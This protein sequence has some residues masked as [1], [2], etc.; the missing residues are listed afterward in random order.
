MGIYI[1]SL[2]FSPC[3]SHQ[4]S[5]HGT[6]TVGGFAC[7]S[8]RVWQTWRAS[9]SRGSSPQLHALPCRLSA[10]CRHRHACHPHGWTPNWA[11]PIRCIHQWECSRLG[12]FPDSARW[13]ILRARPLAWLVLLRAT[14]FQD[15]CPAYI[16]LYRMLVPTQTALARSLPLCVSWR[17]RLGRHLDVEPSHNIPFLSR[18]CAMPTSNRL[19]RCLHDSQKDGTVCPARLG[20]CRWCRLRDLCRHGQWWRRSQSSYSAFL[21]SA[22][23]TT[24]VPCHATLLFSM[25]YCVR[26]VLQQKGSS[27]HSVPRGMYH[28]RTDDSQ[29]VGWDSIVADVVPRACFHQW[30]EYHRF[31]PAS[32]G[33]LI[34]RSW[35]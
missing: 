21:V 9:R 33:W 28:G 8:R 22:F 25:H 26:R 17:L 35:G 12:T 24:A 30:V 13:G 10:R 6:C 2:S 11:V 23:W 7:W 31:A 15:S 29:T 1:R 32:F 3:S 20:S 16:L 14:Y 18:A 19:D 34:W 4:C 5:S 27:H